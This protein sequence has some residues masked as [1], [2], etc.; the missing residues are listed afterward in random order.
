M[1]FLGVSTL[2]ET[3]LVDD[4]SIRLRDL[5]SRRSW[6]ISTWKLADICYP[7]SLLRERQIFNALLPEKE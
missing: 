4:L 7:Y 2:I 1:R 5:D 3:Y 6:K